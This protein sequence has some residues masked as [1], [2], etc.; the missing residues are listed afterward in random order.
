MTLLLYTAP[1]CEACAEAK[2]HL[3]R[4]GVGYTVRDLTDP[5]AIAECKNYTKNGE[6]EAPTLVLK[7]GRK[8]RC[9]VGYSAAGLDAWLRDQGVIR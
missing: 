1:F 4:L 2:G 9:Y 5:Q 3:D 6:P 8:K 7:V